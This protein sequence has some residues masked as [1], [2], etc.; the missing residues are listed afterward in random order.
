MALFLSFRV[1][2]T[3]LVCFV[4]LGLNVVLHKN[5]QSFIIKK[6]YFKSAEVWLILC[7]T[8]NRVISS[9]DNFTF[10]DIFSKRSFTYIEKSNGQRTEP[11]SIPTFML[12]REEC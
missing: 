4:G 5:V 1:N 7:S 10:D 3:C 6:S 9:A 2:M 12:V 11:C 8:E